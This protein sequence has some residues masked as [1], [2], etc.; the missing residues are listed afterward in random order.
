MH[1]FNQLVVDLNPRCVNNLEYVEFR[2]V[3][4]YE[5]RSRIEILKR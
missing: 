4:K 5:M 2:N 1:V 3:L